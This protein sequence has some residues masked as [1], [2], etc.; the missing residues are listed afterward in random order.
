MLQ[1][2]AE[3][4]F[5]P[6]AKSSRLRPGVRWAGKCRSCEDKILTVQDLDTYDFKGTEHRPFPPGA[7]VSAV[8]APKAA[9]AGCV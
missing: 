8:Y 1:I 7:S 5:P 4:D 6:P 9:A 2:L 3:R